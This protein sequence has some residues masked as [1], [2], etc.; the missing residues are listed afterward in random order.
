MANGIGGKLGVSDI[1]TMIKTLQ[2]SLNMTLK[3][4]LS[5]FVESMNSTQKNYEVFSRAIRELPEFQRLVAE[6]AELKLEV[7]KLK[8]KNVCHK[9]TGSISSRQ[10]PGVPPG[11]WGQPCV[12]TTD[13]EEQCSVPGSPAVILEVHEK[14]AG[15]ECVSDKISQIYTDMNIQVE[16]KPK[17]VTTGLSTSHWFGGGSEDED[18]EDDDSDE[19]SDQDTD[20]DSAVSLEKTKC[21]SCGKET[22]IGDH[23]MSH[24]SATEMCSCW[25]THQQVQSSTQ[26]TSCGTCGTSNTEVN[27]EDEDNPICLN[28]WARSPGRGDTQTTTSSTTAHD[29]KLEDEDEEDEDEEDEED[30]EEE[31]GETDGEGGETDDEDGAAADVPDK[32]SSERSYIA[33]GSEDDESEDHVEEVYVVEI[34][35]ADETHYYTNDDE[36]G[37]IYKILADEEVGRKVGYFKDSEPFF[38]E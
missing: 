33:A 28:C 3:R 34:E 17:K 38:T 15:S 5:P 20:D 1:D 10:E 29:H 9:G 36:E 2:D 37:N 23:P 30:E 16:N 35:G 12:V 26:L 32:P 25:E 8:E 14:P 19:A 4:T 21:K 18:E 27:P 31:E 24:N 22:W 13:E 11:G 6:N 7:A